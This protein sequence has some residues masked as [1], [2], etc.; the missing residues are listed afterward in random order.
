MPN[1]SWRISRV[2]YDDHREPIWTMETP[3]KAATTTTTTKNLRFKTMTPADSPLI[4]FCTLKTVEYWIGIRINQCRLNLIFIVIGLL[5]SV[6]Y[7][8]VVLILPSFKLPL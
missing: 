4:N 5:N 1:N 7:P 6:I 2:I 3:N 8:F